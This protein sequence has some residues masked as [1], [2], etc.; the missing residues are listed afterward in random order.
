MI[1]FGNTLLKRS[2]LQPRPFS[3]CAPTMQRNFATLILS[4]HFEGKL[5]PSLGSLLSAAADLNDSTIDVLVHGNDTAAQIEQVQKYPGINKI[6][7]ASDP[8]L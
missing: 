5:S 6:I 4:E 7:V 3:L 8:S 2:A 1:K